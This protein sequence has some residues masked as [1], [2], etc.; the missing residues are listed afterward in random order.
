AR[1]F[2]GQLDLLLLLLEEQRNGSIKIIRDTLGY[3]RLSREFR[4]D[5]SPEIIHDVAENVFVFPN[6]GFHIGFSL[7]GD[8]ALWGK[9]ANAFI[10]RRDVGFNLRELGAL[11]C[12]AY[13][14]FLVF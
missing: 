6:G 3:L 10:G 12:F 1:N 5:A 2:V 11:A 9:L 13:F 8:F 7:L 4:K 14:S